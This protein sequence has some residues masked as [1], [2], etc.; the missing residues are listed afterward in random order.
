MDVPLVLAQIEATRRT[1]TAV[2]FGLIAVAAA[3]ALLTAWY[4]RV[5]DPRRDGSSKQ[6]PPPR[7]KGREE[8]A[9]E[10]DGP[11]GGEVNPSED[12]DSDHP[13]ERVP[14]A[15]PDQTRVMDRE[16]ILDLDSAEVSA[17][18]PP[19]PPRSADLGPSSAS[20]GPAQKR[21]SPAVASQQDPLVTEPPEAVTSPVV[22][23]E[24]APGKPEIDLRSVGAPGA[25]RRKDGPKGAH[26]D[27][28]SF[29]EWLA[30]AEDD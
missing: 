29:D 4:W 26:D 7:R 5:T 14:G 16:R 23:S 28:V 6:T 12:A 3:L 30:L 22:I 10:P 25:N 20:D 1:V 17:Q 18:P 11:S 19:A 13:M 9:P 24:E 21:P 2:V 8:Q 27:G 15:G